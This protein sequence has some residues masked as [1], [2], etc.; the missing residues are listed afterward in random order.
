M[1]NILNEKRDVN[2]PGSD[3]P[4][5]RKALE[6]LCNSNQTLEQININKK[7]FILICSN[8]NAILKIQA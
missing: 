7:C 3:Y 8:S 5:T 2:L 6:I 4:G 1:T